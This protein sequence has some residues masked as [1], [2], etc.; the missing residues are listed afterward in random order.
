MSFIDLKKFKQTKWAVTEKI[1]GANFCFVIE[2]DDSIR[3]GNRRQLIAETDDFFGHRDLVDRLKPQVVETAK[4][5]RALKPDVSRVYIYGELFGGIYPHPDVEKN[6]KVQAVQTGIYYSPN[7]EFAAFDIAFDT[8][9]SQ[10]QPREFLDF[11]QAMT[12]MDRSRLFY[13]VPLF[14]GKYEQA[15]DYSPAF[16]STI[17]RRLGFPKPPDHQNKAEGVVV[18]PMKEILVSSK[19][20]KVR[21]VIKN[22]IPEFKEDKRFHSAVKWENQD[23]AASAASGAGAADIS[24]EDSLFYEASALVTE[25]R[26]ENAISKFGRPTRTDRDKLRALFDIYYRDILDQLRD[27][28]EESFAKLKISDSVAF[29]S[30]ER[31]IKEEASNLFKAQFGIK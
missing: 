27:D 15:I 18:R 26:L 19:K 29:A 21:A 2:S 1:H 14:V 3:A 20:G 22:K 7:I 5:L 6:D 10:N 24:L 11:E 16:E 12:L 8:K 23:K 9:T 4:L 17:S 30:L 31:R 13:V 25:Q 28:N